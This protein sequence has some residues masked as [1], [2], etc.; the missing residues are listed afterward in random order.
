MQ[1]S[2]TTRFS[3]FSVLALL[4]LIGVAGPAA[5]GSDEDDTSSSSSGD[6]GSTSG[7]CDGIVI[8][9]VCEAKCTPETCL[10]GL[11]AGT[12]TNSCVGNLCALNCTAHTD[13]FNYNNGLG[14]PVAGQ[15]YLQHT[16]DCTTATSDTDNVEVQV[17]QTNGKARGFGYAC[18]F[19]NECLDAHQL[20]ACPNGAPCDPPNGTPS[21]PPM[22]D[23]N[24]DGTDD[25]ACQKDLAACRGNAECAV[26]RCGITRSPCSLTPQCDA[27]LC[28]PLGCL[29]AG[30]GDAD[31]Y[32]TR[33]DCT[34]DTD[35][36]GGFYCGAVRVNADICGVDDKGPSYSGICGEADD[37]GPCVEPADFAKDGATY[38]EG[39]LC[40]MRNACM[41]REPCATCTTNVDCTALPDQRCARNGD[42]STA[43]GRICN[44]VN[45]DDDCEP[46]YR[47]DP[48]GLLVPES[49][50]TGAY[51]ACVHRFGACKGTGNFCE[52]CLDDRDCGGAICYPATGNELAC[53]Q[54]PFEDS[55]PGGSNSECPQAPGGS[56]GT[57]LDEADG[58][59]PDSSAY[60]MCFLP[61]DS[62]TGKSGCWY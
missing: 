27:N 23:G 29:G 60:L 61:I 11:D 35:C 52:P 45:G 17:C 13:C 28:Q 31:A 44:P 40:L 18:P 55:C 57:C 16:Q 24:A 51:G 50:P 5:C 9:D 43:C 6:G 47:C 12:S 32:C 7:A 46:N 3:S 19:G 14:F 20:F 48:G 1:R 56:Y 34:A 59:T 49:G 25:N 53:L 36:P 54:I 62:G 22:G 38:F 4:A 37:A 39:P 21:C 42:Q 10:E 15:G 2:F 26:G 30:A 8:D 58:V 33:Y 41:K